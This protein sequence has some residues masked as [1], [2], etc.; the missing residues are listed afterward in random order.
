[1]IKTNKDI[2]YGAALTELFEGLKMAEKVQQSDIGSMAQAYGIITM[3]VK[4]VL[5][6]CSDLSM[7]DIYEQTRGREPVDDVPAIFPHRNDKN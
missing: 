1:M 5:I 2:D 7:N 6:T 3:R 4:M